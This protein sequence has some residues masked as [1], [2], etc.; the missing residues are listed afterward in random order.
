H[1]RV[2]RGQPHD[3]RIPRRAGALET[4]SRRGCSRVAWVCLPPMPHGITITVRPLARQHRGLRRRCP[5]TSPI[6]GGGPCHPQARGAASPGRLAA[7]RQEHPAGFLPCRVWWV[8]RSAYHT[9]LMP[10]MACI[11][12]FATHTTRLDRMRVLTIFARN[13]RASSGY[14]ETI[15][16]SSLFLNTLVFWCSLANTLRC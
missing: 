1:R 12:V 10:R 4:A 16:H 2:G 5:G 6:G 13:Q 11:V 3:P 7:G 9:R 14:W 15:D 8:L